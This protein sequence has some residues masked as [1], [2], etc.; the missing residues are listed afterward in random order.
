M[1]VR[2]RGAKQARL[3][4]VATAARG[5]IPSILEGEAEQDRGRDSKVIIVGST[6]LALMRC[7]KTLR[8]R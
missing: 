3:S 6:S 5:S 1:M 7:C 8:G 4:S 2:A